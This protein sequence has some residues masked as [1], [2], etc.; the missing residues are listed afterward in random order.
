MFFTQL[1]FAILSDMDLGQTMMTANKIQFAIER[2]ADDSTPDSPFL[3]S[4]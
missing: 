4:K 3:I 2:M 1:S